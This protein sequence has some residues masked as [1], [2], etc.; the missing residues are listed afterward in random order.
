[1]G[2]NIANIFNNQGLSG[3]FPSLAPISSFYYVVYFTTSSNNS[4]LGGGS[5]QGLG[6]KSSNLGQKILPSLTPYI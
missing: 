3:I 1:M 4:S 5:G 6:F 2:A